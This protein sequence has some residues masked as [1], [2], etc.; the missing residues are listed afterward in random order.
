MKKEKTVNRTKKV[1]LYFALFGFLLG[2]FNQID[3]RYQLIPYGDTSLS[4][5]LNIPTNLFYSAVINPAYNAIVDSYYKQ[6]EKDLVIE[7][8]ALPDDL[9]SFSQEEKEVFIDKRSRPKE[10]IRKE[11][12]IVSYAYHMDQLHRA[13]FGYLFPFVSALMWG[14]IG[15]LYFLLKK[16]F[17][18]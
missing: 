16:R 4:V 7:E 6:S 12:Y 2:I 18:K 5:I 1:I 9:E 8:S 13:V 11:Q 14:G 17:A 15:A 10:A 3:M